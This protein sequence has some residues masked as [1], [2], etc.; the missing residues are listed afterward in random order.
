MSVF[1]KELIIN[2]K[3]IRS[4]EQQV[5]QNTKDIEVLKKKIKNIYRTTE[6]LNSSST[7]VAVNTTNCPEDEKEGWLLDSNA[8][9][10]SITDNNGTN[11][12]LLYYTNVRAI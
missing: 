9:L 6:S 12:L 4:P 3:A 7:S 5:W 11:L 2:G 8:N 1:D 10:F